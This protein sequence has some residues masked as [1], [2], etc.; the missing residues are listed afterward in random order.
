[1]LAQVVA[2][3]GTLAG[4]L[5]SCLGGIASL[6]IMA[7]PFAFFLVGLAASFIFRIMGAKRSKKRG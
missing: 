1:M 4:T 7:I 2:A 3:L 6:W 5:A